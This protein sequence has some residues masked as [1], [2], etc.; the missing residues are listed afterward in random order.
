[1]TLRLPLPAVL[2]LNLILFGASVSLFSPASPAP[3]SSPRKPAGPSRLRLLWQR[4]LAPLTPTWSDQPRFTSDSARKPVVAGKLLLLSCS[5]SD[6]LMAL[7]AATGS[8]VWRFVAD[9]P[10]RFA[11]AAWKERVF[12]A[13]DDGWLYCLE[14]GSGK[15]LWSHRGGPS[16]RRILGNE[17]LIS[18]WP[19]RGGPVVTA[20][21]DERATVYY[22]AGVWPFMGIFLHALD[23][24]TGE[25][26]WSNSGDGSIYVKQPH[27]TDSF[28]G[29]GPQGSLVVAGDH[30]FVP[31][32]R[33]IAACYDRNTGK[34]LHYRLADN[35]KK[36]GG[37]DLIASGELYLNGGALFDQARGD[38]LGPVS[39]PADLNGPTLYSVSG[40]KCRA[41]YVG[42]RSED[43]LPK[44][45]KKI[46]GEGWLCEPCGQVT[47]PRSTALLAGE[48]H[49]YGA[50]PGKVYA[51]PLPLMGEEAVI[52]EA[53]IS[54]TPIHLAAGGGRL[55]VSTIEGRIYAFAES[56]EKAAPAH[57]RETT[58]L[59]SADRAGQELT[60]RL[61][62]ASSVRSGYAL[63]YGTGSG[64][65]IAELLRQTKL[66][67]IV[68]EPDAD[69]VAALRKRLIAADVDFQRCTVVPRAPDAAELPPYLCELAAAEDLS[70]F[71]VD[72][73]FFDL[74]Y[75]SLRPY[76]GSAC[77]PLIALQQQTLKQ[78]QKK[79]AQAKVR[80]EGGL[81]VLTREGALPGAG[82]W[83]HE[84]ADAAN[85]RV[86]PDR[87]VKAPLGL[88]WYGGP[89]NQG[90]LPRHGHG[91]VPQAIDGR[92]FIEG[93]DQLRAIDVYTGRLLW[94]AKLPGL[95]KVYDNL[96]HQPGANAAGSNYV[97][98]SEGIYV[99]H[100]RKCVVLD[101]ATGKQ[102]RSHDLPPMKGAKV[103][104][105][106]TFVAVTGK[107]LIGAANP[108]A[109]PEAKKDSK[110]KTT[111]KGVESSRRLSVLDRQSGKVL[112]TIEATQG[113]RHN[114]ICAGGGRLYAI[115][116]APF[117][118]GV[119]KKPE[120]E[121]PARLV[122]H[123]LATGKPLW[124]SDE[125]V[126][127]TW[128]SYSSAHDVLVEAGLTSRD[129][130]G[131]E[132]S[133][134][135]AFGAARGEV[136]WKR[137]DYNGPALIH[138][139]RIL[140]HAKGAGAGSACDVR[141]GRPI[142]HKDPLTG[143]EQEWRWTRNYGCNTPAACEN[144]MLFRSGAAG[145]YDLENE[146]GTGNFGGF[147]SSCTM[148]LIAACGV[149]TIPDYTRTCTCSYQNQA[150][151]G[152]V[153]APEVETWTF[154][155]TKQ[156]DAV[157]RQ[158]GI[159]FGAP[160]ARKADNGTLWIEHPPVGGPSPRPAIT[161]DVEKPETFRMHAS[162]V[163]GEG[164]AWTSASG[165]RGVRHLTLRLGPDGAKPRLYTVR[166]TFLEPDRIEKGQRVFDVAIQGK[167]RLRKLDV[168]E[169]AG[170]VGRGVVREIKGVRVGREL[171]I[172][173]KPIA[174]REP[175]LS[176]VEVIA[177]GW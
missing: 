110:S 158:V 130:L 174:G 177:E 96:A 157:I 4:D 121:S 49:L 167:T 125:E 148:N 85:T 83:T 97:C 77:L 60:K 146:G 170:G 139:D 163:K 114:A 37:P 161:T 113:F 18:S 166:L 100:N 116:R 147:R 64:G 38:H 112:W 152:L 47:V 8:M 61:L 104:P 159:N 51:L 132:A 81:T 13:S 50:G 123:D 131:D 95:G 142:T 176:A 39:E 124:S 33:S 134:M 84:H 115:D 68:L 169:E 45:A 17:R 53:V 138:G 90:I 6:S 20:E 172:T 27:N 52:S 23:A 28:A 101:P 69:R 91:P 175:V 128:L 10:I 55:F 26:R 140:K 24:A 36:G 141:T 108:A 11:P 165:I 89:G 19:A 99:A 144:L 59:P 149:L 136:L 156:V 150:S 98:T 153:H 30:L 137:P 126:F 107:Y 63:V 9:G 56:E 105:E 145:Y 5:R 3:S 82:S 66:N 143:Q 15:V 71:T 111:F 103:A 41:F 34:L 79:D 7:D 65:L 12:V 88:L 154:S 106:W 135:R 72:E 46:P 87:L 16:D 14:Q 58:P 54:G 80:L 43:R 133:G 171:A 155:A 48:D 32:G 1:M 70:G 57:R 21:D 122:C 92:L 102:V 44:N 40:T 151:V 31:G 42:P 25:V 78:W 74:L 173:L 86:S 76:G 62:K 67:L 35:S 168:M 162:Q 160:G 29:I 94:E 73:D 22:A 127:G 93:T 120:D 117:V 109:K 75:R 129:T 118:L 119:K 164:P 2:G